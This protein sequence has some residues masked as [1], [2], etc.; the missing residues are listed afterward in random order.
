[1]NQNVRARNRI[2]NLVRG[3]S[4]NT[5]LHTRGHSEEPDCAL[6]NTSNRSCILELLWV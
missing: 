5:G 2:R 3:L 1:M 6:V 4:Y